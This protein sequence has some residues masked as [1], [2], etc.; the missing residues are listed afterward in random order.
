MNNKHTGV[1]KTGS[2][3]PFYSWVIGSMVNGIL[4]WMLIERF[5]GKCGENIINIILTIS[6]ILLYFVYPAWMLVSA[7]LY[8]RAKDYVRAV[9][10]TLI[11]VAIIFK[12]LFVSF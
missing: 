10:G 1:K 9:I 4:I 5:F 2:W 12:A 8:W 6:L 3:L 7:N 11:A